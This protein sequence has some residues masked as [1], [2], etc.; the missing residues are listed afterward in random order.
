MGGDWWTTGVPGC[1]CGTSLSMCCDDCG[2]H[3]DCPVHSDC[4]DDCVMKETR[5]EPAQPGRGQGGGDAA[6]SGAVVGGVIAAVS[7]LAVI[8]TIL[9]SLGS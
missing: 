9:I 8:A 1:I 7:A 5:D 6:V 4:P 2:T 3:Y